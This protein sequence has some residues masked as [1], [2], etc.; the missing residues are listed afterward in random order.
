MLEEQIWKSR[1]PILQFTYS[2]Q[3]IVLYGL[4]GQ[5]KGIAQIL[6]ASWLWFGE[7]IMKI[8]NF[9]YL[10]F[11]VTFKFFWPFFNLFEIFDA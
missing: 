10:A 3:Y 1:F 5:T 8:Q 6:N 11:P 9:L 2:K 7:K 4:E